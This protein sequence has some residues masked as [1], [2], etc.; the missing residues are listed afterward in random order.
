[1]KTKIQP[2]LLLISM[3]VF[4]FNSLSQYDSALDLENDTTSLH[5][6][7]LLQLKKNTIF[8]EVGGNGFIYS[9]NYDRLIDLTTKFKLSTRIGVH[10]THYVPFPHVRTH[11]IPAEVSGLYSIYKQKHFIE[12]GTGLSYMSAYDQ[13]TNRQFDLLILAF[14]AGYR[15]Q[16]PEGGTFIKVGF[17]PLYD[18]VNSNLDPDAPI[19]TWF[20]SG[21]LGLGYTF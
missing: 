19:H 17:V 9:I 1:M 14:R 6:D 20:F 11:C 7:T 5:A 10:Y 21:G 8:A 15:F 18:M 2:A 13:Y 12:L 3:F 4:S 16:K